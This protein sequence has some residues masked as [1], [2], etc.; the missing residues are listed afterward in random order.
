MGK[1]KKVRVS[2][3]DNIPKKVPL[4]DQIEGDGIVKSKQRNK[5]RYRASDDE[6][7]F[8][9]LF[10]IVIYYDTEIS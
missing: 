3:G 6:V 2:K 5:L 7:K 9:F 8:Y 4:A 1:A 10:L